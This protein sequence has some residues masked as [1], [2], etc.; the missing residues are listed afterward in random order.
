MNLSFKSDVMLWM[1]NFNNGSFT[2]N[3]CYFR[4]LNL[5]RALSGC[6][7]LNNSFSDKS[8]KQGNMCGYV[9]VEITI[10]IHLQG[11]WPKCCHLLY[12]AAIYDKYTHIYIYIYR[13]RERD[14]C[15][16]QS[17]KVIQKANFTI[18]RPQLHL[19]C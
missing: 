19:G 18:Y 9:W 2:F 12:G 5:T 4:V 8:W 6:G 7:L 17:Q 13:E 14:G 1:L 3:S 15:K 10:T 11:V 16:N